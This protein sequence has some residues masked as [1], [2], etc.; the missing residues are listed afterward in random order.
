MKAHAF[1]ALLVAGMLAGRPALGQPGGECSRDVFKV[2][3][4]SLEVTLCVPPAAGAR[5]GEGTPV[6]VGV[7]ETFSAN[8]ESFSRTVP[9]EFLDGGETLRTIDDVPL[10]KLGIPKSLH[11]TIGYRPG[12]VRLEHAMLVPGAISLK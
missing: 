10:A 1:G 2:D 11:L 5:R 9:L 3:G 4:T 7:S 6:K 12:S 8:G